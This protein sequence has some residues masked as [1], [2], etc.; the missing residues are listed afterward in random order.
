M[1]RLTFRS[2][3]NEK[4]HRKEVFHFSSLRDA[5][6]H[7]SS[8]LQFTSYENWGD[9]YDIRVEWDPDMPPVA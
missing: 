5:E 2:Y 7:A 8:L 1:Y 9:R 4:L 6:A 3:R